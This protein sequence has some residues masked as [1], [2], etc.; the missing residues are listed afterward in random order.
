MIKRIFLILIAVIPFILSAQTA[1]GDWKIY[2]RY[3]SISQMK[4]TPEKLYYVSGNSLYSL[5]KNTKETYIYTSKNKLNESNINK[6]YYNK[7]GKYLVITYSTG[8]IDILYD[9]GKV[10]NV[11]YVKDAVLTYDADINDIAFSGDN[12][13]IATKFGIIVYDES[14]HQ[15]KYSGFYGKEISLITLVGDNVV[16]DHNRAIYYINKDSKF[17]SFSDFTQISSGYYIED[18]EG[19][20]NNKLL[21][22]STSK[23]ITIF[24]LNFE[25]NNYSKTDLTTS[26][27]NSNIIY[28]KD[29]YYFVSNN[30]VYSVS[31]DGVI[32]THST[33][34]SDLSAQIISIWDNADVLWAGDNKGVAN[35]NVEGGNITVLTDK[36]KP[37]LLTV[38]IPFFITSDKKGKVY[39]STYS[40]SRYLG[41]KNQWAE[42]F[43]N[44]IDGN[45]IE[46][47]TP[48]GLETFDNYSVSPIYYLPGNKLGAANQLVIDPEDD[49]TYYVSTYWDGVYKITNGKQSA[50][51]Y[52]YAIG[53][54]NSTFIPINGC[55]IF[56]LGFDKDNNLWCVNE[57]NANTNSPALHFLPAEARKKETTVVEDWTPIQL[58]SFV[59]GRDVRLLICKKS[60]MI[61]ICDGIFSGPIVAYDTKGTYSDLSDDEFYLWDSFIDQDGKAYD[62]DRTSALCEDELGRV[63]IGTTNGIIEIT[64]PS[65]ATDP[66]MTVNRLKLLSDN[67][68]DYSGYL[69]GALHVTSISVDKNNR[70]WIGTLN[71]GVYYANEDGTK[72]L[73]HFTSDNSYHPGGMTYNVYVHP[74]TGSVFM[75]T[76]KG[77]VEYNESSSPAKE[78]Y[79][80]VYVYP[81]P[82][83]PDYTGWISI[84]GLMDNSDVKITDIVGNVVYTTRSSGGSVIWDGC[85]EKGQRIKAGVYLVY[86]SNSDNP[87]E[88]VSKINVVN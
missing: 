74:I 21:F 42:S 40:E 86:A 75:G 52:S 29:A 83:K 43:I 63:W 20:N 47:V 62:P 59:G 76:E 67:G 19:L 49:D 7:E 53:K 48:S 87:S 51:Y 61:F 3:S 39:V 24:D 1:K 65:K 79:S 69:L 88:L 34:T 78:D 55:R 32:N 71:N 81:N 6:I 37:E 44:T 9:N 80:D 23:T 2:S 10:V 25:K 5:D 13:Y 4:Q 82:I 33:I 8:N 28:G 70:K 73:E 64:D 38:D 31:F 11:P 60:N 14:K 45:K 66:S 56:A 16:I 72:I 18:F 41:L 26:T 30:V 58:G 84:K 46:D 50:H 85:D 77:L 15:V 12:I 57:V 54:V 35:Y 36:N 27:N 22:R 68:V 17:D